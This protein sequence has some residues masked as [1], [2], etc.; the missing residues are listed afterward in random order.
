MRVFLTGTVAI[1]VAVCCGCAAPDAQRHGDKIRAVQ[2]QPT[3]ERPIVFRGTDR[4]MEVLFGGESGVIQKILLCG[5]NMNFAISPDHKRAACVAFDPQTEARIVTFYDRDGDVTANVLLPLM[6]PEAKRLYYHGLNIILSNDSLAVVKLSH[7]PFI[8]ALPPPGKR[9]KFYAEMFFVDPSHKVQPIPV[10]Q[11][12]GIQVLLPSGGG[13][14]LLRIHGDN[15]DRA[16]HDWKLER[17]VTGDMSSSLAD[18][19]P[20]K[21]VWTHNGK[22]SRVSPAGAKYDVSLFVSHLSTEVV[23]Y[24]YLHFKMDGAVEI[25]PLVPAT[26]SQPTSSRKMDGEKPVLR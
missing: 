8:D 20:V 26:T 21:C 17:Y 16:E 3:K 24:E 6:P 4:G 7:D 25:Q 14:A 12:E 9:P 2:E 15:R 10:S 11:D 1:L 23:R 5:P 19:P 18:A 22:A 13:F